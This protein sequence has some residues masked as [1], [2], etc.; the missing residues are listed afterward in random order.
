MAKKWMFVVAGI[1]VLALVLLASG[2]VPLVGG[3]NASMKVTHYTPDGEPI[4]DLFGWARGGQ[5]IADDWDVTLSYTVT[6]ENTENLQVTGEFTLTVMYTDPDTLKQVTI[7]DISEPVSNTGL[8]WAGTWDYSY[9]SLISNPIED[10][11][12]DVRISASLTAEA[13]D[14]SSGDVIKDSWSGSDGWSV[15]W[16]PDGTLSITGTLS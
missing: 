3:F 10:V 1:G 7:A 13:T 5:E 9:S 16:S 11:I 12:Y 6:T 14:V 15:T 4:E 2:V 8:K